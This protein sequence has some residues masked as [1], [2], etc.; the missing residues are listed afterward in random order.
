MIFY[1]GS[2]LEIM[3]PDLTHSRL[4]VDFGF[5]FGSLAG[6]YFELPGRK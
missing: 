1:H 4:N 2:Y 6:F 3:K 5:L